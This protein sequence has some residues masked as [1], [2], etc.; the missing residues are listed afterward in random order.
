MAD[1]DRTPDSTGSILFSN[2]IFYNYLYIDPKYDIP[3]YVGKGKGARSTAHFYKGCGNKK[4]HN[5]IQER[6]SEGYDMFPVL[7][8]CESEEHSHELEI[9]WI[10]F[11]G[12]EDLGKGTLFNLTDGGGGGDEVV[13]RR[14]PWNKNKKSTQ[15]LNSSN[16]VPGHIPWNK[17]PFEEL[18]Y[19]QQ[20]KLYTANSPRVPQG[21]LPKLLRSPI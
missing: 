19:Q 3:V 21:W 12:R 1:N 7:T 16:W 11:F 6:I 18:P 5:T 4:L 9:F 17:K 8:Y 13:S 15:P 14:V 2:Q 20:R 10:D